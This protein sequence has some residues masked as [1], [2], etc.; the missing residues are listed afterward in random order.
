V[1]EKWA[2]FFFE[3]HFLVGLSYDGNPWTHDFF[4]KEK[5]GGRTA[6]K[7]E[8]AWKIL[9]EHHV[10]TNLLC[11]VTKQIA[12]K[13]GDAYAF[14]K[15]I[16]ARYLQFIPCIAPK[17]GET[18]FRWGLGTTEYAYFL[19][20]L[21]DYWYR[22]WKTGHYISVRNFD[23]Y[24]NLMC[25]RR[26]STC[27]A[28]GQCGRYLVVEADGSTYPCDFYVEDLWYLG[29]LM[30]QSLEQLLNSQKA[31]DFAAETY[32]PKQC[33][34]C[35]YYWICRGGCKNDYRGGAQNRF[36]AA[37]QDF[38]SYAMDRLQQIAAV[39]WKVTGGGQ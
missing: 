21:F 28:C 16:G 37:Y 5:N 1:D 12:K 35:R 7:V 15:G 27:A 3:N 34:Q 26:P 13:P 19:K 2:R 36:C 30:E 11:V 31:M 10:E 22:D 33:G 9:Q 17:G 39:E 18:A 23:D 29:N 25:H 32:R 4:R 24:V 14:L 8:A 20:S 38:F 6:R